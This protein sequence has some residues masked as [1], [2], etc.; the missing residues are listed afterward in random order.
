[1]VKN[2]NLISSYEFAKISNQIFSGVFTQN[3]LDFLLLKNYKIVDSTDN[4]LY[5][6]NL[7]FEIKENDII[8]C[9][10]EDVKILFTLIASCKLKNIK[11]ITHQSDLE[12]NKKLYLIKPDCISEWYGIN[13]NH[14]AENLVSIPIGLANEHPKNL[15]KIDFNSKKPDQFFYKKAF[16]KYLLFINFQESTN[17][18]A[19]SGLYKLFK[20]FN[21]AYVENPIL[22]KSE[23]LNILR[24]SNFTLAPFGNGYDTHRIWEALYSNSVPIVQKHISY[25]YLEDL[26]VLQIQDFKNITKNELLATIDKLESNSYFYEKLFMGYWHDL[27]NTNKI[28]SEGSFLLVFSGINV[29][30]FEYKYKIVEKLKSK[31]KI[32]KYFFR[33]IH[34]FLEYK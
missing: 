20:K 17:Y 6:R 5:I 10:T 3:Q 7:N 30:L 32:F 9:R 13:I 25:S 29:K 21:W 28:H 14:C 22:K 18:K 15:S 27:I 1:M 24:N 4:F 2:K 33:R 8:F 12:I 16:K 11:L 23:Y 19:R 31:K 26:P 34:N